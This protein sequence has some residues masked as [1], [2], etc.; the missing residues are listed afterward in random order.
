MIPACPYLPV[1]GAM[2]VRGE[3]LGNVWTVPAEG[4]Y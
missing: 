2:M 4:R 1:D 3:D